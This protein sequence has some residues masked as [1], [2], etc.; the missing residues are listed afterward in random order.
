MRPTMVRVDSV[1]MSPDVNATCT[2]PWG[3][4]WTMNTQLR[5]VRSGSETMIVARPG[6]SAEAGMMRCVGMIIIR[7]S[8]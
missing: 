4:T 5:I 8:G 6:R 2:T 7:S 1:I 3:Q